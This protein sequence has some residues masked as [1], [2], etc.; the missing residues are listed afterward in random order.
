MG[1]RMSIGSARGES[2]WR[3]EASSAPQLRLVSGSDD[4]LG[5]EAPETPSSTASTDFG[6]PAVETLAA[7]ALRLQEGDP[8]FC[9]GGVMV[10]VNGPSES[11]LPE[12]TLSCA[13]CGATVS[14]P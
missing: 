12:R 10:I 13:A 4:S 9:C 7:Y 11:D 5:G 2:G 14:R 3:A 1:T 6:A 8:C